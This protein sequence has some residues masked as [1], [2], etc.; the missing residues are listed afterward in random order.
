MAAALLAN[1]AFDAALGT[2]I[3]SGLA[4][5]GV[6]LYAANRE[7]AKYRARQRGSQQYAS[8]PAQ[9]KAAQASVSAV[10]NAAMGGAKAGAAAGAAGKVAQFLSRSA[11]VENDNRAK[12]A[13]LDMAKGKKTKGSAN[14]IQ[15]GR[16]RKQG[17][18]T[19]SPERNVRL[20]STTVPIQGCF[21]MQNT[22]A[23]SFAKVLWLSFVSQQTKTAFLGC[24]FGNSTND[25]NIAALGPNMASVFRKW[26][27]KKLSVKFKSFVGSTA[28]GTGAMCFDSDPA[29]GSVTSLQTVLQK[30]GACMFDYKTDCNLV[31]KAYGDDKTQ[32]KYTAPGT[33][34]LRNEDDLSYGGLVMY[35]VNN[36]ALNATIGFLV[37]NA[38]IEFYD[39]YG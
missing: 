32:D 34:A 13:L 7:G 26:R 17:Q 15:G 11:T 12:T 33:V 14:K 18:M 39:P 28:T 19:S 27:L 29:V 6:G 9:L 31:W 2:A 21:Q 4:S 36:D 37:V 22:S 20:A 5:I 23:G 8:L 38:V 3:A 25:A 30:R 35:V 10:K 16:K 1:P 24:M